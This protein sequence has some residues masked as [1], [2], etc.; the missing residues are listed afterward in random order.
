MSVHDVCVGAHPPTECNLKKCTI[1]QIRLW[2]LTIPAP[3]MTPFIVAAIPIANDLDANGLLLYLEKILYGLLERKIQVVSYACDGTEVE[4]AVQKLLVAKADETLE[5]SIPNPH[6]TSPDIKI[7]IAVIRGQPICMIQDSKHALKTFR[8]NLF[9]GARLLTF[10]NYTAIFQ[11]IREMASEPGSPLYQRDVDK[12]DRQD[13]NAASRLFSADVL[14][15]LSDHH[16]DHVGE[17]IYLF[18]FGELID[19]YQ[20]CSISHHER[21]KMVLRARYFLDS[22]DTFLSHSGYKKTQYFLS[23]EAV[24]IAHIIIEGYISLVIIH[25]DHVNG[26]VP[27]LPWL[28]SSEACEHVFGE[29]RQVVKD[30]TLLDFI[31]MVP[32]LRIR[33]RQAILC[34]LASDPKARASG[35]CHT[36]FD[37]T[38]IDL[39]A[40]ASYPSDD[41]VTEAAQEAAQEVDSL[42]ALLGIVPGQLHRLQGAPEVVLPSIL[43]LL[44]CPQDEKAEDDD[45]QSITDTETDAESISEAQELQNLIDGE[46]DIIVSRTREQD[47]KM[48]HLTC[49]AFA[50]TADEMMNV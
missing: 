41:E 44:V 16:P 34:A 33:L 9:S 18:I 25:R 29:A 12:I 35:Y 36:Y 48:L 4:R 39:R 38:N 24:D 10:G 40:L 13:D 23:R 2:C 49:A 28:H 20:N 15:Y 27:L 30:F 17:I 3:K 5:H 21:L 32:K 42:I 37:H 1:L 45:A 47:E 26:L 19:A 50:I 8:N 46:E 14:Q 7:S 22:W 11:R 43:S 31:Y 6:P